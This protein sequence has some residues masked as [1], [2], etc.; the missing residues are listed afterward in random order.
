MATQGLARAALRAGLARRMFTQRLPCAQVTFLRARQFSDHVDPIGGT[1]TE[2]TAKYFMADGDDTT[3][4]GDDHTLR[5]VDGEG[6]EMSPW[7]DI[8]LYTGEEGVVKCF[9]E[10]PKGSTPNQH[11]ATAGANNPISWNAGFAPQTYEDPNDND[12]YSGD[13]DPV[14]VVEIGSAP[15]AKGAVAQVK[16]VGVLAMI[17]WGELD[18]KIIVIRKDDPLFGEVND[19]ADVDAKCPG[20]L[21]SMREWFRGDGDPENPDDDERALDK[22]HAVETLAQS[23]AA[24]ISL[25]ERNEAALAEQGIVEG[26]EMKNGVPVNRPGL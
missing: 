7:H 13:N 22:A 3:Y 18:N 8:D 1:G 17:D 23:H 4:K 24:W 12:G 14:D 25:R 11:L 2:Q 5:F 16:V 15:I 6:K 19:I 21:D 26:T 10:H 20:L 9:F